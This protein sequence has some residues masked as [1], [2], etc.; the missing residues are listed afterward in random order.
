MNI[1][2]IVLLPFFIFLSYLVNGQVV[3]NEVCSSNSTVLQ[4]I[5]GEYYDWIELYNTADSAVNLQGYR[6]SDDPAILD[7]WVF[8]N[9]EIEAN[10]YLL[11]MASDNDINASDAIADTVSVFTANHWSWADENADPPGRS[12]IRPLDF[13]EILGYENGEP[14]YSLQMFAANNYGIGDLGWHAAVLVVM[15][16]DWDVA[17]DYSEY[18]KLLI[19][20]TITEG[21]DID[22]R[23]VQDGLEDW[24]GYAYTITGTGVENDVY[25]IPLY[26]DLAR[27]NLSQLISIKYEGLLPEGYTDLRITDHQ[28]VKEAGYLHTN[29]KLSSNGESIL[30]SDAQGVLQD[31]I[32]V[33]Q[34]LPDFSYGSVADGEDSLVLFPNPSAG[35]SNNGNPSYGSLCINRIDF[36]IDAGF[37]QGQVQIELSGANEIRYTLDG[38][39]PSLESP[40]YT[41]PIVS[42]STFVLRAAC[43]DNG[44]FPYHQFTNTYIV[45]EQTHLPVFSISTDPANFFDY[46]TGIYTDGPGWTEP[47]P[48][49]GAN[50]WQEW[51]RPIHI[52]YF[53]NQG[54]LALEQDAETEIFGGWSRMNDQKSLK[55]K[56]KNSLGGRFNYKFFEHKNN[57]SYK[58]LVLRNSGNDFNVLHFHDAIVHESA[59]KNTHVDLLAYQPTVVFING[60]YWGIQNL[61]EKINDYYV[62]DNHGIRTDTL[63]LFEAWGRRI[64]EGEF[65]VNQ[66]FDIIQQGNMSNETVFQNAFSNF[67]EDNFIDFFAINT[68]ISNWDWPQNNLKFWYS[69]ITHKIRYIMYDTDI[70][71]GKFGIQLYDFNQLNRLLTS[72]EIGPHGIVFSKFM[73]NEGLRNKFI[74]RSADLMNTD[75]SISSLWATMDSIIAIIEPEMPKHM[76]RWE[77]W[78]EDWYFEIDE[79]KSFI[80]NRLPYAFDQI[81]GEFNLNNQI[82]LTLEVYPAGAGYI[83]INTIMPEQLPW[84]G[85]YFDG[86][87][88]TI[89]AVPASGYSFDSWDVSM[90]DQQPSDQSFSLNFIENSTIAAHFVGEAVVNS[91]LVS[92]INYNSS[93]ELNTGDWFE[94]Y[95]AGTSSVDL[96][97]WKIKDRRD[98]GYYSFPDNTVIESGQYIVFASQS[99]DFVSIVDHIVPFD[100]PFKLGNGGDEIRLFD[101][102]GNLYYALEFED[103][104]DMLTDG[105][106]HTLEYDFYADDDINTSDA[107][108]PGCVGGSPGYAYDEDCG[109]YVLQVVTNIEEQVL[110]SA[111][112]ILSVE[113]YNNLGQKLKTCTSGFDNCT[114]NLS[115]GVYYIKTVTKSGVYTRQSVVD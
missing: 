37:Y 101:P 78:I 21:R 113:V 65:D 97:G 20:A 1:F 71:L 83:K 27:E 57:D 8:E 103:W 107:W 82:D 112:D 88:V 18:S 55:L 69:P 58:Q 110:L 63:E 44:G 41:I 17:Y 62:E 73:Q 61:R 115:V 102:F 79:T 80:Q 15:V 6:I 49:E 43:F 74:N 67:E 35:I 34:L 106:G 89:T 40:L 68:I 104:Y 32:D 14:V 3:I 105:G 50:Y 95:N 42:D 53:D 75:F 109:G 11:L 90:L 36:S 9:V 5:S 31:R 111:E 99:D 4:D 7:K 96:T 16:G 2:K 93:D 91:L 54:N 114:E 70:S 25:E 38:N 52:E 64:N 56:S 98:Y 39:T 108:L 48:H 81:E 85:T 13:D 10:S 12:T 87:P 19:T 100:V 92:E 72:D 46:N 29:F 60:Y 76:Q 30:L 84:T 47:M 45:N 26:D 86:V 33:P 66:L 94:L 77:S 23:L 59:R 24:L 28:F 22:I 51:E